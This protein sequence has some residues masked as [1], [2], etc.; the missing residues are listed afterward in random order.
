MDKIIIDFNLVQP[1]NDC[2]EISFNWDGNLIVF[3]LL[4]FENDESPIV[5][6]LDCSWNVTFSKFEQ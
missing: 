2:D 3:K 4:Q 6:R 1:S 5:V